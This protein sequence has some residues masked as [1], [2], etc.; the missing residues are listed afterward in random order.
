MVHSFVY[1]TTRATLRVFF[2]QG[3][4]YDYLNV[5]QATAEEFKAVCES[6]GASTGKWF[7]QNIRHSFGY[8]VFSKPS[9]AVHVAENKGTRTLE[10]TPNQKKKLVDL[11]EDYVILHSPDRDK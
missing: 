7:Y 10:E 9:R 1:D 4:I 2:K 11:P 5:P 6:P 3:Q 8:E